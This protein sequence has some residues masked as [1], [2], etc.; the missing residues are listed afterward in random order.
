[1]AYG[2]NIETIINKTKQEITEE[3]KS[4]YAQLCKKVIIQYVKKT[5]G[6]NSDIEIEKIDIYANSIIPEVYYTFESAFSFSVVPDRMP[7]SSQHTLMAN[8][9]EMLLKMSLQQKDD[10][11]NMRVRNSV[12]KS[13]AN[14]NF[15][16]ILETTEVYNNPMLWLYHFPCDKCNGVGSNTCTSCGGNGNHR[17]FKCKG[18]GQIRCLRFD[19][20]AG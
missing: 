9:N 10:L 19:T 13:L 14:N 12:E 15:G 7:P 11:N 6:I 2:E 8:K 20:W 18:N 5:T 1:M 4:K 17:C 3:E 16:E